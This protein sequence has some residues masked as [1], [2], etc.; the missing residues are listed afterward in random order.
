[1]RTSSFLRTTLLLAGSGLVACGGYPDEFEGEAYEGEDLALVET[2]EGLDITRP[3]EPTLVERTWGGASIAPLEGD[4]TP[5]RV[6]AANL[7]LSPP[8]AYSLRQYQTSIKTQT[9]GECVSQAYLGALEAA[10]KRNCMDKVP[11]FA[12]AVYCGLQNMY[13]GYEEINLSEQYLIHSAFTRWAH[14]GASSSHE[15]GP[16]VSNYCLAGATSEPADT[17]EGG[18]SG[19]VD[20]I[21][22]GVR[23]PLE[24]EAP[25]FG[26]NVAR[27]GFPGQTLFTM[28]HLDKLRYE[29][30][31][32]P[33]L[34]CFDKYT[35]QRTYDNYQFDPEHIPV[36]ASRRAAYGAQ[37]AVILPEASARDVALLE[38]YIANKY[39]VVLGLDLSW[40]SCPGN[41]P[42]SHCVWDTSDP[43]EPNL[44]VG[45]A[46]LAIGYDRTK[47]EVLVKNSWGPSYNAWM[48]IPYDFVAAQASWGLV[49]TNVLVP[50]VDDEAKL[51][52]AWNLWNNGSLEGRLVI[53]RTR[54]S[55]DHAY[56]DPVA[57]SEVAE[58]S[59]LLSR[60]RW[61]TYYP[62][63]ASSKTFDVG[64]RVLGQWN[65][66]GKPELYQGAITYEAGDP[67]ST[68]YNNMQLIV[69][70]EANVGTDDVLR[71]GNR[72]A[73][74]D[75]ARRAELNWKGTW[76]IDAGSP[77]ANPARRLT[78]TSVDPIMSADGTHAVTGKYRVG[79]TETS[80][81]GKIDRHG[82]RGV[83]SLVER[84]CSNIYCLNKS[85]TLDAVRVRYVEGGVVKDALDTTQSVF[86]GIFKLGINTTAY[87]RKVN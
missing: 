24:K 69:W 46:V 26:S 44:N 57:F 71:I 42:E 9:Q 76:A 43:N 45:H 58:S 56:A 68:N 85:Y 83:F 21:A 79:T 6:F 62:Y 8:S 30:G 4:D 1:M 87:G 29:T 81:T 54:A 50:E 63:K 35:Y 55:A 59:A 67:L 11:G 33:S 86:R 25:L 51:M 17:R 7:P 16:A 14:H 64:R 31:M 40:F 38:K 48:W 60:S 36:T 78:V 15:N 65:N 10:Y 73:R 5:S 75:F 37:D 72:T 53:H 28:N 49:V 66:A 2:V 61:G 3:A 70:G 23:L 39:E 34:G 80:F 12:S 27:T 13:L 22:E 74:R 52:G 18:I 84:N 32:N 20:T 47:R 77:T 19:L 41:L 82:N